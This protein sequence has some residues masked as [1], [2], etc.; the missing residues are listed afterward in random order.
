MLLVLR[1]MNSLRQNTLHFFSNS[2]LFNP[3]FISINLF[4]PLYLSP[5]F[6]LLSVFQFHLHSLID[7]TKIDWRSIKY[8]YNIFVSANLTSFLQLIYFAKKERKGG[9]QISVSIWF[10]LL[11][12]YS[13]AAQITSAIWMNPPN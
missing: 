10:G 12:L 1:E 9:N 2:K 3:G 7:L 5:V 13:G 6:N 11:P 4:F 8:C